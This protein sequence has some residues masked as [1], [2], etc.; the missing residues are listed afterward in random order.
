LIV[1]EG[2]TFDG[3][4]SMGNKPDEPIVEKKA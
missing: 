4:S 3:M 2:A 1:D